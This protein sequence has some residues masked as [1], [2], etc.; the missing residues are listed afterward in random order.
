[1]FVCS[2]SSHR[3]TGVPGGVGAGVGGGTCG[4][5]GWGLAFV[6]V[7][8]HRGEFRQTFLGL[9]PRFCSRWEFVQQPEAVR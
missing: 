4:G 9:I 5:Q 7:T 2:T 8:K 6:P 1:M 3:I